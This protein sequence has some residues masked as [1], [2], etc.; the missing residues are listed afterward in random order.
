MLKVNIFLHQ[1]WIGEEKDTFTHSHRSHI[2]CK[3][4]SN[5]KYTSNLIIGCNILNIDRTYSASLKYSSEE[6]NMIITI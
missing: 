2:I 6:I 4:L 5:F 1:E 3:S